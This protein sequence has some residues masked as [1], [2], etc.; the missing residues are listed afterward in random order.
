MLLFRC[1]VCIH[2]PLYA[3]PFTQLLIIDSIHPAQRS[4]SR[5]LRVRRRNGEG[6]AYQAVAFLLGS[7]ET[8]L[9][10]VSALPFAPRLMLFVLIRGVSL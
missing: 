8:L 6:E 4:H 9:T 3:H 10:G 1:I 2:L 7:R 5:V